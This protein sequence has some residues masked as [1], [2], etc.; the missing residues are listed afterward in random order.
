[1]IH[2]NKKPLFPRKAVFDIV[3]TPTSATANVSFTARQYV[4]GVETSD[5]SRSTV[6]QECLS[7]EECGTLYS[8]L[9]KLFESDES[10]RQLGADEAEEPTGA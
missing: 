8:I 5:C 1:M 4:D 10:K 3:M 7:E 9:S 2:K 6:S